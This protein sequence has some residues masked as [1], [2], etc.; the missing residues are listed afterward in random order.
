M[1]VMTIRARRRVILLGAFLLFAF[2]GATFAWWRL[3]QVA[4]PWIP[5]RQRPDIA[6]LI[7]LATTAGATEVTLPNDGGEYL[8]AQPYIRDRDVPTSLG[9]DQPELERI[10]NRC[11]APEQMHVFHIVNGRCVGHCTLDGRFTFE[12]TPVAVPAGSTLLLLPINYHRPI[13]VVPKPP[14]PPTPPP[15]T[16]PPLP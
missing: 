14:A 4:R 5:I 8:L 2:S 16:D 3:W 7:A 13:L 9:F 15:N 1:L 10:E 12:A 11:M 6:A